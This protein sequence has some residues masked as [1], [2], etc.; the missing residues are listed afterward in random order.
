MIVGRSVVS[1]FTLITTRLSQGGEDVDEGTARWSKNTSAGL[2]RL[3][4]VLYGAR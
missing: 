4:S 1:R 2:I 3:A